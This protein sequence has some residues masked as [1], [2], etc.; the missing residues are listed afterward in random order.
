VNLLGIYNFGSIS[1][2]VRAGTVLAE[3]ATGALVFTDQVT[4]DRVRSA[5]LNYGADT[6][7]L[8]R[9]LAESF[10]IT[11]A[12]RG[13]DRAVGGPSLASSHTF[14]ELRN[15][16]TRQDILRSLRIGVALGLWDGQ[17]GGLPGDAR[18]FGR[19]TVHVRADYDDALTVSLF[20][21]AAGEPQTRESYE[22]AGR[23]AIQLLVAE[24]D[25]DAIR[26][27]PALDNDLWRE[28]KSRGQPGFGQLFPN[29]SPPLLG[30]IVADYSTIVWWA[31][32][33]A[34]AGRRLAAMRRFCL[35]NPDAPPGDARFE[36]LRGDLASHLE[37]VAATTREEFG[38][39]WGL[40]AMH[41]ASGR[42]APAR[43]LILGP[44]FLRVQESAK[45]RA[46]R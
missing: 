17:T 28:M 24:D 9:V 16:A 14:F 6:S 21:D 25:P 18:D 40:V 30:A 8:R 36:T 38:Q 35:Q 26:R 42:R 11:A 7:K 29:L 3:P 10:L 27:K 43:I 32:A 4:A 33:M 12:Y 19:T 37:K 31:Q 20:L 41:Q 1:S 22:N 15:N 34:G 39:P 5:L 2:L 46:A 44:R 23:A 45:T 13:A